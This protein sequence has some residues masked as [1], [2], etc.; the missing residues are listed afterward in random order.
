MV[1]Y[2]VPANKVNIP[3]KAHQLLPVGRM[4]NSAIPS[5]GANIV[6][7][8]VVYSNLYVNEAIAG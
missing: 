7:P 4:K 8:L 1:D 2:I 3:Q 5:Y 6:N